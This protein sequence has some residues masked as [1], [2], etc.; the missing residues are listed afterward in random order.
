ML[1]QVEGESK[2]L[3]GTGLPGLQS[4]GLLQSLGNPDYQIS[5]G[6]IVGLLC[7]GLAGWVIA[8][9]WP[10]MVIK[11]VGVVVGAELG[12]LVARMVRR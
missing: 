9:K 6:D 11:Y 8:K 2:I 10:N 4:I 3:G 5:T 7:G 1:G 12:I